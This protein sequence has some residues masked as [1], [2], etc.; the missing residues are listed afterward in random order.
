MRTLSVGKRSSRTAGVTLIEMIVVVSIIAILVG[1]SFP[2]VA[3]GIET[4]RLNSA[5]EST[6]AFINGG[7][8]RAER[9]QQ[10]VEV[11]ISKAENALFLRSAEPGFERRLDLPD[12]IKIEAVLPEMPEEDA[13]GNRTFLLYPGGTVPAFGIALVNRKQAQRVVRVDPIT[14]VPL[15]ESPGKK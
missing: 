13:A 5:A 10:M 7:V 1:I 2:S 14:G 12:G 9:R 4:L 8:N 15:I 11:I 3:S 6:V